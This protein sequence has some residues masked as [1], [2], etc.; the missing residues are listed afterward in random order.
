MSM[1]RLAQQQAALDKQIA[2][3]LAQL[4]C[5]DKE[6]NSTA[7]DRSAVQAALQQLQQQRE[8]AADR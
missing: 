6:K 1:A 2:A 8:S 4:D 7:I 5:G 3:Y